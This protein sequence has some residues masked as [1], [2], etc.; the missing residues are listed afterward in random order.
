MNELKKIC[1]AFTENL[2]RGQQSA[3]A[4]IVYTSGSTYRRAGARM[5]IAEDGRTTGSISSGYLEADVID[6]A[7]SV[8]DSGLP[9][10]LSYDTRL[11]DDLIWSL[12][13]GYKGVVEILIERLTD[14][15]ANEYIEFLSFCE[16]ARTAN[17]LA[18]VVDVAAGAPDVRVGDRLMLSTVGVEYSQIVN[19][20][21]G[22]QIEKDAQVALAEG[23]SETK[24]YGTSDDKVKVF[25]EVIK[26]SIP[27]LIFS[28]GS[29]AVPVVR[30][31]KEL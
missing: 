26:P 28:A 15:Q 19:I 1:A 16:Y 2:E 6:R 4:T 5:L 14:G 23:C 20:T 7:L 27:R 8:I 22:L 13:F 9:M 31:A 25:I 3:L 21:L 12:G 17:V 24:I 10:I 18:T 11:N 29:D 30:F